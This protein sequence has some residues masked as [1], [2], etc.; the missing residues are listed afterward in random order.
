MKQ[1]VKTLLVVG[2]LMV[3]TTAFAQKE[4]WLHYYTSP[5]GKSYEYIELTTNAPPDLKLPQLNAAPYF[6]R[7]RT[8]LDPSGG[9]WMCFDRTRKSGPYDRLYI[10]TKGDGK[11]GNSPVATARIDQYSAT[12]QPVK[13]TFKGE[14]GLIAYHLILRFMK[15]DDDR[16]RLLSSSGGYYAGDVD[17]GGKK[18]HLEL[19]DNNVNATFNDCGPSPGEADNIIIGDEH[20]YLG[21]MVEHDSVFY[22]IEVARDGAFLKVQKAE[23]V[24]LGKVKVP[25]TITQFSAFGLNGHFTRKP[26]KGE[27]TLP[28]GDYAVQDWNIKR[29]DKSNAQWE[30]SAY[31]DKEA[32]NFEVVAEKAAQP[33]VGEPVRMELKAEES[34]NQVV[35]RL[36][37]IGPGN[38]SV[39][40]LK[41]NQRPP[42]PKLIL[43]SLDG[44]Y[45]STNTF[46]F[47]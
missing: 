25:E 34:T 26:V 39:Q 22:R 38:E 33:T 24:A 45:R 40:L 16:A 21:K 6:A 23:N 1:V 43:A 44:T 11:L 41:E 42:G 7:W 14:D 20:R 15:Y 4:Q 8:P 3:A 27:F 18:R 9:R 36:S 47:G 29:K 30:M 19:I 10:D 2:G 37:F 31:R 28:V 17:L 32:S 35:F 13:M 12:F 5:Q 46:E